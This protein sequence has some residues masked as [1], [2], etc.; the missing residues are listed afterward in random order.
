VEFRARV[1][2]RPMRLLRALE[3]HWFAPARMSDLAIARIVV[4]GSQLLFFLPDLAVQSW[5]AGA[6]ASL[7]R[8][9]PALKLLLLPIGE[10][11]ARP[12]PMLL[13]GAWLLS[14]V[15]GVAGVLGLYTRLSLLVFAAMNT[16]LVA[17]GYSYGEY[18]HP[19]GL[20]V[21]ALWVLAVAPSGATWS[22]D[23]LRA[24]WAGT[25]QFMKFQPRRV[26]SDVSEFARWPLRTIQ[27]LFVLIYLSAG[28]SKVRN[29]GLEWMNGHTLSY[30]LLLD[31]V[32]SD[33]SLSLVLAEWTWLLAVLSVGTVAFEMTFAA[34]IVVPRLVWPYVLAGTALHAGIYLTQ[35]AP[36]FQF[37]VLYIVFLESL[38]QHFPLRMARGQAPRSSWTVVYDGYCPRCLRTLVV[39][40]YADVRGKLVALDFETQWPQAAVVLAGITQ[41]DARH[42]MHLVSPQGEVFK[43][44]GAFQVLA[45]IL[46]GLWPVLPLFH[47]PLASSIG[48]WIYEKLAVNR[49]RACTAET[50]R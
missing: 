30:Y 7:F 40:D 17:H 10:W 8:P 25:L 48:P 16:L 21:I 36:F 34:A 35:R 24:R 3:R 32:R 18:H 39:L 4:V 42:S 2:A 12:D 19:E 38:R 31:G 15:S 47:L 50:C 49:S 46:P 28:L 26:A 37:V 5:L 22:A 20:M 45:R 14:V 43:G 44:Y 41:E 27:W 23:D 6:D 13:R 11:G 9:I 33:L 1:D 29:G